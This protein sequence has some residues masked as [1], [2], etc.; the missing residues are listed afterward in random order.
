MNAISR[1]RKINEKLSSRGMVNST[2]ELT[3]KMQRWN[4]GSTT[5]INQNP[6]DLVTLDEWKQYC[7]H[8]LKI[9]EGQK[10]AVEEAKKE[11][12]ILKEKIKQGN[13]LMCIEAIIK[14]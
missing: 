3:T 7:Q 13:G 9:V 8:R 5:N 6:K 12:A 14:I 2:Y 1:I 11:L 10:I 4:Y